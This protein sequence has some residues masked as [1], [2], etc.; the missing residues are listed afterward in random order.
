[1]PDQVTHDY[2]EILQVSA[3]A[4]PETIHR[5]YRLLAMR[6]HP[7]NQET[8][9]ADRFRLLHEAYSVLGDPEQRARYDI[10]HQAY[11]Q[12]RF[13][14]VSSGAGSANNFEIEREVRFSVL[15]ALYTQRRLEPGHPGIFVH[16]VEDLIGTAREHL[17]FTMW[18]LVQKKLVQRGDNSQMQITADGADYLEQN[19]L[20]SVQTRRLN[21]S[22]AVAA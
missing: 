9:N 13:R 17:E 5:V 18:Y 8:G 1:M 14:V 4:E 15:E 21:A 10:A 12:N 7:D 20:A 22:S 3:K 16:D 2:Y 11:R 6:F 19:Y